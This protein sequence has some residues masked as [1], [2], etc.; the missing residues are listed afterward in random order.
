MSDPAPRPPEV[1]VERE[2]AHP[3]EKVW[4]ALTRPHL[5]GEWLLEND[6]E[7]TVGHRFELKADWGRVA[8]Q[9]LVVDPFAAL[10][11][12]WGD[13]VLRSTVTWT[14][15]PTATGTRLRMAQT[16]FPHGQPR[17]YLGAQR[18]W[19]KFLSNLERTLARMA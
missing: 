11:Y 6:F 3:P 4:R 17:Y 12:T 19:P 7:A 15:T 5:I 14:L 1:V 2:L 16:G 18:G 13:D 9:V 10:S 8:G